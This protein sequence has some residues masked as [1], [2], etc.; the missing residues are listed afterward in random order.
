MGVG[1]G[2]TVPFREGCGPVQGSSVR[3]LVNCISVALTQFSSLG[4]RESKCAH[5]PMR[6]WLDGLLQLGVDGSSKTPSPNAS[7]SSRLC[8]VGQ[9]AVRTEQFWD[10]LPHTDL[11]WPRGGP[12]GSYSFSV[13]SPRE[14]TGLARGACVT[15]CHT[16]GPVWASH[17]R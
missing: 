17:C 5:I 10:R 16:C 7:P 15:V 2:S 4:R 9:G 14:R 6:S 11:S 1:W 12:S 8:V 3:G 13:P